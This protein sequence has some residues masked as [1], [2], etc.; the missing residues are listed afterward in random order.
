ALRIS[1]IRYRSLYESMMDA[2]VRTDLQGRILEFNQVY[3]K[4]AGFEAD[5][6]HK[7]TYQDLTPKKW[8]AR[9]AEITEKQVL[10]RGYS[11]VYEKEYIRKDGTTFPVELRAVLLR[12]EAGNPAGTWAL[13]RDISERKKTE[14]ALRESEARYRGLV[15]NSMQWVIVFQGLRIVYV[16]QA[17][18]DA[19]GYTVRELQAAM[20][21]Q[22]SKWIHP[23]DRR[24]F[25]E[26]MQARM[27]G[28]QLA[29]RF[30]MRVIHKNG[31]CLW[32]E[33]RNIPIL[34]DNSP[35]LLITAIDVTDIRRVEAELRESERTQRSIVNAY[36]AV[37]FL[38]DANGLIISANDKFS[39][40][41]GIP[42]ERV[43]GTYIHGI[44]P[45]EV[46]RERRLK[47]NQVVSSGQAV[48]FEDTR[49]GI[50]F[51]NSF[52]PIQDESGKVVRVAAFIL[53]ITEK[54][55]MVDALSA[56]EAKYRS[57]AETAHDMIYIIDRE[58]RIEYI[59]SFGAAFLGHS[60]KKMI[61]QARA[62]YFPEQTSQHQQASLRNV[63]QTGE[64]SYA[65]NA[66][67]FP[68][69]AIWLSTSLVPL[70]NGEGKI[71]SV[72]GV[73]RDITDQKRV[74]EE[75]RQARDLLEA[76]VAE[77]TAE[78]MDSQ[79]KMRLLTKQTIRDQEEE[80][81]I[82]AR[83][84]HDDAGQ[85]LVTLQYSLSAVQAS[86]P[87]EDTF[88]SERLADSLHIIDQ[89]IQH[90][91]SMAHNLRPP[92]LD[93][94]GIDLSLKEYCR[95]QAERTRIPIL[96]QGKDIPG[97]PSEISISLYRFV[98]EAI[99]NVLKHAKA[100]QVKV[101][102]QH[103]KGEI[104]ITVIDNGQGI[105]DA[106][107]TSGM[108]LEG[109]RER[110]QLLGGRLEVYSSKGRGTKLVALV[111]WRRPRRRSSL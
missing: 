77:R 19:L 85:A 68:D 28:D 55:N 2:Y 62:F 24:L 63:M 105:A 44:F 22:I 18:S 21:E 33:A 23:D 11:D 100:S 49:N 87:P 59:N 36:D 41:L 72:L 98:Q 104:F 97:L 106:H 5:E 56:S 54:K 99:T 86:L 64:A 108:G 57:L 74:E 7:L 82:L 15:D 65:E 20:P 94:G 60:P 83:E 52:Y 42:P 101:R 111:P 61:G 48:I 6:L 43:G 38:A 29:E 58:D 13:I 12:D 40:R 10:V 32:I 37:V 75:L 78:L 103:K 9:E 109:I 4:M 73:S 102:L 47:F 35:A 31:E 107:Q 66:I 46:T 84:L 110:L 67:V 30:T 25:W 70:R 16:N 79:E 14:E 39:Q 8:H 53:D 90:I 96:Y 71:T 27:E 89:T 76:R 3:Q 51:E 95:E 50:W 91:R 17:T 88:S 92:V 1:E 45:E 69:R 26:K 34:M 81:R 80:R 93:I